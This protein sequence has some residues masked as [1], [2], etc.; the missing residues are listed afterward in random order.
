MKRINRITPKLFLGERGM[1]MMSD[2]L[3]EASFLL[4]TEES[5]LAGHPD[6]FCVKRAEDEKSIGTAEAEEIILRSFTLPVCAKHTVVLIDGMEDMTVQ[7]QNKL[8]KLLEEESP[9]VIIA[10]AYRDALLPTVK[11]RMQV[12]RYQKRPLAEYLAASGASKGQDA[13]VTYYASDGV[14][15]EGNVREGAEDM[16]EVIKIFARVKDALLKGRGADL[17]EAFRLVRE[18]DEG[19]FFLAH[20]AH[21]ASAISFMGAVLTALRQEQ[22]CNMHLSACLSLLG[23]HRESCCEASYTKDTFFSCVA[24][25]AKLIEKDIIQGGKENVVV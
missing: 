25:V 11:S 20:P 12:K 13:L 23:A 1:P 7:A 17:F 4:E 2:A 9:L 24:Q 21:V 3:K 5:A 18:K 14:S 8:L 19:H 10:V 16:P 15:S 6:F 22:P